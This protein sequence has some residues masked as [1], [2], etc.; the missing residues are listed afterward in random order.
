MTAAQKWQTRDNEDRGHYRKVSTRKWNDAWLRSKSIDAERVWDYLTTHPNST[1]LPGILACE[2]VAAAKRLRMKLEQFH[3]A[4]EELRP[5]VEADWEA[6]L[7]WLPTAF[8]QDPPSGPNVVAHWRKLVRELPECPLLTRALLGLR[9]R[10]AELFLDP[11]SFLKAFDTQF[12]NLPISKPVEPIEE[13]FPEPFGD[14]GS[15]IQDPALLSYEAEEITNVGRRHDPPA[16]PPPRPLTSIPS[17]ATVQVKQDQGDQL[18]ALWCSLEQAC[19]SIFKTTPREKLPDEVF[20]KLQ[21]FWEGH[22]RDTEWCLDTQAR[23]INRDR[24]WVENRNPPGATEVFL[25]AGQWPRFR[26]ARP[27]E[28]KSI[29][30]GT[31]PDGPVGELWGKVIHALQEDGKVYA[32]SWLI[33]CSPLELIA[34]RFVLGVPDRYFRDW[35]VDHYGPLLA[36]VLE[37]LGETLEV[38]FRAP[39]EATPEVFPEADRFTQARAAA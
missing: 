17:P 1:S 6:G 7:V 38:E 25:D 9:E 36:T 15:R 37:Q 39:E 14:P 10:L 35:A 12:S 27:S 30:V 11:S 18:R 24:R 3:A 21:A 23:W 32:L 20:P 19:G 34:G 2:D 5:K 29:P 16:P 4:F 26:R 13:P 28:E 22:Q 8:K 33:R 31:I